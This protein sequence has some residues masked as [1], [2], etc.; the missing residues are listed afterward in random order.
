MQDGLLKAKITYEIMRPESVGWGQ[1]ALVLGKHS[2][3]HA[4][5]D[6]LNALGYDLREEDL[7]RRVRAV[8]GTRGSKEGRVR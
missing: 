6:R 2:G 5:R 3:R 1:T 4:L 7:N 8:Q